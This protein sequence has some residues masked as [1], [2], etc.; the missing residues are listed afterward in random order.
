MCHEYAVLFAAF[1]VS[2]GFRAIR[3]SGP[4]F[5]KKWTRSSFG[6]AQGAKKKV[7]YSDKRK[8]LTTKSVVYPH[9]FIQ[10]TLLFKFFTLSVFGISVTTIQ[11][12]SGSTEL[13]T[14]QLLYSYSA[15]QLRAKWS[16]KGIR[17]SVWLKKTKVG[18]TVPL[19]TLCLLHCLKILIYIYL[20][21]QHSYLVNNKPVCGGLFKIHL[22]THTS[23]N[24]CFRPNFTPR[25][26]S[27]CVHI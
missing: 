3:Y 16:E 26:R 24:F 6:D 25:S 20:K 4:S 23:L 22:Y 8:R 17:H 11:T 12:C 27:L 5:Q 1:A 14:G 18:R 21:L 15:Q 19:E 2:D 9:C 10:K 13:E 7:F